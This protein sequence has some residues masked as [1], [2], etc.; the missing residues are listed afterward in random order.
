MTVRNRWVALAII[1][2]TFIQFSLNWLNVVPMF[3]SMIGQMH[4]SGVEIA[5]IVSAFLL[6]FGIV[7]VPAGVAAEHYGLRSVVVV[8]IALEGAGTVLTALGPSYSALVAGRVLAGVGGSIYDAGVIGLIGAWFGGK[9]IVLASGLIFGAAFAVGGSAGIYGWGLLAALVGWRQALLVGA[10][11]SLALLVMLAFV[12]PTPREQARA[13]ATS[14]SWRLSWESFLRAVSNR[15]IWLMGIAF[16]GGYGA[17]LATA[18]LAPEYAIHA[19]KF[20]PNEANLLGGIFILVGIPGALIGGWLGDRLIGITNTFIVGV[21]IEAAAFIYVF[22]LHGSSAVGFWIAIIAV[23][24]MMISA[25]SAWM[26]IP[27]TTASIKPQDYATAGGL[28]YS[29]SAVAG[30][31]MPILYA[32]LGADYGADAGWLGLGIVTIATG[33]LALFDRWDKIPQ[34]TSKTPAA[35][36]GSD[37]HA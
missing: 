31:V 1:F 17:Y 32:K 23:G 11:F 29:I 4:I 14:R 37:V 30:A 25:I 16:F 7:H 5:T 20:S 13:G 8:G 36:A 15:R 12:D 9:E 6:G 3:P 19:L 35:P 10:L 33:A 18:N 27:A 34:A 21:A 26:G 24:V 22:A 28:L 2:I